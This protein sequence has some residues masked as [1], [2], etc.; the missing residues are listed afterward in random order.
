MARHVINT[1]PPIGDPANIA[2]AK[3]NDNFAELFA[4]PGKNKLINGSMNVWQR[5]TSFNLAANSGQYTADRWAFNT[6]ANISVVVGRASLSAGEADQF[7]Y[8]M[9]V[10]VSAVGGG[11]NMRQ[12]IEGVSTFAG[13]TAT[14]SFWARSN[15]AGMQVTIRGQQVFGS[16]GSANAG[17][18]GGGTVTLTT[19]WARYDVQMIVPSVAGKAAGPN[20]AVQLIFDYLG[21][22]TYY[23]TGVQMEEGAA[24]T[25]FD[26]Q[27]VS[28]EVLRCQRYYEKSYDDAV[29]PGQ[30]SAFGRCGEFVG[31]A[32]RTT[33]NA[34]L[35]KFMVRKRT[36]PSIT[37]YAS[38]SGVAANVSQDNGSSVPINGTSS[39]GHT[40]FQITWTNGSGRYGGS[41]HYTADAEF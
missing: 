34:Q 21:V 12:S 22:G 41:F 40:G 28:D 4:R 10:A 32:T 23:I 33:A 36:T 30:V 17:L 11:V 37:I 20:N 15:F 8:A 14:L 29:F 27:F 2:F 5:N 13:K 6:G 38:E 24:R 39:P 26:H 25:D 1:D 19:A 18:G 3:A 9:T 7:S 31:V 35:V 16:G